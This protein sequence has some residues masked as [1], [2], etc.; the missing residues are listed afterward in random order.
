MIQV[1]ERNSWVC[2]K[3]DCMT[4][5][6][7]FRHPFRV[8]RAH[9]P[10]PS[11][12]LSGADEFRTS[13]ATVN[14]SYPKECYF[15]F[16]DFENHGT[17]SLR[18]APE[19]KSRWGSEGW[20]K[21]CHLSLVI[22]QTADRVRTEPWHAELPILCPAVSLGP[23]CTLWKLTGSHSS[24]EEGDSKGGN[25]CTH[26]Q[27]VVSARKKRKG[28]DLNPTPPLGNSD[29]LLSLSEPQCLICTA[30]RLIIVPFS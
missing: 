30:E 14:Q 7:L 27:I 25:K 5:G 1:Q 17:F 22:E 24:E 2:G 15:S 10:W 6:K 13:W 19:I 9:V 23:P 8:C 28:W 21:G 26:I 12:T 11:S 4:G 3:M 20:E 18:G 29:N 16:R